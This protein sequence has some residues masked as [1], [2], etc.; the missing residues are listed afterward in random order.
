[1]KFT[2]LRAR[3]SALVLGVAVAAGG[4]LSVTPADA[5][6]R[7]AVG[8]PLQEAQSLA[9]QGN[10]SA[11]MAKVN[12]AASVGGLTGEESRVIGQMKAYIAAKSSAT[13]GA[14]KLAADYRAGRWSAVIADAN[15]MGSLSANDMAAVATAYY[16]LGQ[17]A[18]CVRY[19]RSH[20][21]SGASDVV[22]KIQMAC[23][24]EAGDD[25]AQTAALE[26]LVARNNTPE[27]WGQ[28]LKA[29]ERTRGLN[30]HQTLDIY[31]VKYRTGAMTT[32]Q[33][34]TLLAKL[35]FAAGFPAEA[36]AVEKKGI[37]A[38]ILSGESTN[39][40][41]GMTQAQVAA[42]QGSW[43]KRVAEA[44]A[45]RTG[46]PLIKLGEELW[47]QD[48][49]KEAVDL[50]QEGIKKDKVDNNNAQIRLG[51]AYLAAGRKSDALRA[52]AAVKGDA[53][54]EVIAKI[55]TLYAKK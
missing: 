23:A 46:D 51:T 27:Y 53:R 31:R 2:K 18:Q 43:E 37:D 7:P 47:G 30:D 24:F 17:H 52:F 26:Q 5:A 35:A 20:F 11:A 9:A 32:A 38:K 21:G 19:I 40:L 54:W 34:Y 10:Y 13:S 4:A 42:N 8:K 55:W 44:R 16:K 6:V 29:A 49:G 12:Q 14:G 25:A 33:D 36:L 45:A 41:L 22:L 39:R 15:S 1:M 3:F 50:I 48:K 28:Y